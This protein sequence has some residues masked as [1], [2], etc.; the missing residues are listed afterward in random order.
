MPG[1]SR[2]PLRQNWLNETGSSAVEFALI[3]PVFLL[4]V[5]GA[6]G[7]GIYFGAAHSVQQLAA[8]AARAAVAGLS[9]AERTALATAFLADNGGSYVLID[10]DLLTIEAAPSPSDPDQ[11]LVRVSYDASALPIWNL[12]PPLPLP[13]RTIRFASTIRNGGV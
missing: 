7:Y 9:G 2:Q 5:F 10:P 8:D 1:G 3:A 12:H 4:L 11:F 6:I 13:D